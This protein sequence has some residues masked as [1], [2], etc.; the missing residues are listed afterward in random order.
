MEATGVQESDELYILAPGADIVKLRGGLM[1]VKSLRAVDAAGLEQWIPVMKAEFP[2]S[3][4]AVTATFAALRRPPPDNPQDGTSLEDLL[5]ILVTPDS[6]VT[7]GPG[8][9]APRALHDRWL[10]RRA[11]RGGGRGPKDDDDRH[12]GSRSGQGDHRGPRHR[13]RRPPEPELRRRP[14][15]ADQRR[16][17]ALR[18]DRRRDELG[19]APRLRAFGRR[20]VASGHRPGGDLPA[21]RGPGRERQHRLRGARSDG[22]RHC[23]HGR[24]SAARGCHRRGCGRDRRTAHRQERRHG[25]RRA[26]ASRRDPAR[27]HLGRGGEPPRVRGRHGRH[28]PDRSRW[29]SSTPAA[30]AASSRSGRAARSRSASAWTSARSATPSASASPEPCRPRW[31]AKRERPLPRT[32]PRSTGGTSRRPSSA[33]GAPSPT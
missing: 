18:R 3:A 9:Q 2:L 25:R 8:P 30:A 22:R 10:H 32:W 12:R 1:D 14:D 17:A 4:E 13:A 27:G 15:R 29:P 11:Q 31:S 19:Q 6:G 16:P 21:G 7:P 23:R 24:G 20:Q 33:W 5:A 28:R 26:P